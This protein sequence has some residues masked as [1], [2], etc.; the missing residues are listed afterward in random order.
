VVVP[1]IHGAVDQESV[2]PLAAAPLTQSSRIQWAQALPCAALGGVFAL[3]LLIPFAALGA[4]SSVAPFAVFGVAFMVGG[5][6]S[7]RLYY[8]KVKDV[9]IKPRAGAQVGAA[10]GGFGFLFLAVLI[11]ATVIYRA[12]EMRKGMADAIGQLTHRGYDPEMARQV[13]EFL[14]TREGLAFFVGFGLFVMALIFVIGASIGG[15]WYSAW[16][17]KR[18]RL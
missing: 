7:V 15:A 9:P 14:K 16:L 6:W 13:L 12:D 5:A 1:E 8:R 3:L 11:A 17:R 4:G 10:R 18:T 2:F